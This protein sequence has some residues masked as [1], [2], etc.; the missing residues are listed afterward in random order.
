MVATIALCAVL[1]CATAYATL[2][3][4]QREAEPE[5]A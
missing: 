1:A 2:R 3:N 5:T 4:P